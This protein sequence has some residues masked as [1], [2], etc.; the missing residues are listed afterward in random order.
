MVCIF[1]IFYI[2]ISNTLQ[3]SIRGISA[4]TDQPKMF[5]YHVSCGIDK[6]V[7]TTDNRMSLKDV[8]RREFGVSSA[9]V[10]QS[11]D[12]EFE[13]WVN[14]AD[15]TQLTDK[16]KLQVITNGEHSAALLLLSAGY[17]MFM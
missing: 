10:L 4:L 2:Y 1:C 15:V 8:I 11:W 14:V 5:R 3:F 13:D 9:L 7:V 12:G 6:K 16:C 17:H